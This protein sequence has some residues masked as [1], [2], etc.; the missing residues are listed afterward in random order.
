MHVVQNFPFS[1]SKTGDGQSQYPGAPGSSPLEPE[2]YFE[3]LRQLV[4][5]AANGKFSGSQQSKKQLPAVAKV[6]LS[7][8]LPVLPFQF[9]LRTHYYP[10]HCLVPPRARQ[11]RNSSPLP[12]LSSSE[13][14]IYIVPFQFG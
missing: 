2:K 4:R 9:Q 10:F 5:W 3:T 8:L 14:V 1:L 7:I 13:L 6:G 11:A 12:D